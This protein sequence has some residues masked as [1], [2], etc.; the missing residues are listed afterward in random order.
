MNTF[1]VV[2]LIKRK[3]DG[4]FNNPTFQQPADDTTD[5]KMWAYQK[6][7]SSLATYYNDDNW[8]YIECH[9]LR[10]DGVVVA[11]EVVDRR[12]ES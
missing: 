8:D 11:G 6:Y 9:I 5:P 7:H 3:P 10:S 12:T 4:T 2:V 1:Y